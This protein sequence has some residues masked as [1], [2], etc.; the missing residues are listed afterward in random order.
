MF[1]V[2]HP[3]RMGAAHGFLSGAPAGAR[4]K[5]DALS[6]WFEMAGPTLVCFSGGTDSGLLAFAALVAAART[7]TLSACYS[8]ETGVRG[9]FAR[10][11]LRA[12]A[13]RLDLTVLETRIALLENRAFAANG[14]D[15]CY[16]CKRAIFTSALRLA[17]EHGLRTVVDGTNTSDLRD[18]RPGL[19]A[20][21]ECGIRSPYLELGWDKATIRELA[22]SLRLPLPRTSTTCLATRFPTGTPVDEHLLPLVESIE[23]QLADLGYQCVRARV[24]AEGFR[25]EVAPEEVARL[26]RDIGLL[27]YPAGYIIEVDPRG[28]RPMGMRGR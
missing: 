12:A 10:E 20:A 5:L 8:A 13:S 23:G 11:R 26:E 19:R 9:R 3:R 21:R 25:I 7:G 2:K 18:D 22:E 16:V 27:T 1:H 17:E 15:R 28:Y 24:T 6:K 4:L 14:P